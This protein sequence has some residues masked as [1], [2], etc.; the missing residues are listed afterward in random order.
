MREKNWLVRVLQEAADRV[1]RWPEWKKAT[2]LQQR[3]NEQEDR[4]EQTDPDER[5]MRCA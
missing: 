4:N 3:E 1:D 5:K 2:E